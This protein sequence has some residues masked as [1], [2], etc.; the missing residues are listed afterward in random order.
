[1]SML[2][3]VGKL[4]AEQESTLAKGIGRRV[5][6]NRFD[7]GGVP[8]SMVGEAIPSAHMDAFTRQLATLAEKHPEAAS[9]LKHVQLRNVPGRSLRSHNPNNAALT[10]SGGFPAGTARGGSPGESRIFLDYPT[11]MARNEKM[12][13]HGAQQTGEE[14]LTD[15][16][17]HEFGHILDYA[18]GATSRTEP[19]WWMGRPM[20]E[21]FDIPASGQ[22]LDNVS[23]VIATSIGS[24]YARTNYRELFAESFLAAERGHPAAA[25]LVGAASEKAREIGTARRGSVGGSRVAVARRHSTA[26]QG[27][28][29]KSSAP[30]RFSSGNPI[31]DAGV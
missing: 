22:T 27:L 28:P 18:T 7:V 8:V 17:T 29:V 13:L 16:L 9:H 24:T 1:M 23:D 11:M 3:K 21:A 25:K 5:P 6:I 26:R 12:G 31:Y 20:A 19:S 30:A 2:G 10:A 15:T 4:V 14:R